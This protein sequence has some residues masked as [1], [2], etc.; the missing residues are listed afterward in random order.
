[1]ANAERLLLA[2]CWVGARLL[3]KM[4]EVFYGSSLPL[5]RIAAA[6]DMLPAEVSRILDL[7][8]DAEPQPQR[9]KSRI[10]SFPAP[11]RTRNK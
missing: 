6:A 10:V 5:D 9:A 4:A 7:Y 2:E 11:L 3:K 1:M 8:A